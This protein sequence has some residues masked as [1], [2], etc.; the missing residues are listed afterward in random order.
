MII[1]GKDEKSEKGGK[2]NR[3]DGDLNGELGT[4][5]LLS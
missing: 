4:W 1:G 2:G 5:N 3:R